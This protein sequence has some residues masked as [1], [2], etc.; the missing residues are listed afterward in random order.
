MSTDY[1]NEFTHNDLESRQK[2][3]IKQELDVNLQQQNIVNQS[4][5]TIKEFFQNIPNTDPDYAI[6]LTQMEMDQI[7]LD[8]LKKREDELV[9][10]IKNSP[11]II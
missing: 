10:F 1:S 4:I 11:P 5:K 8:E 2:L 3:L 9:N 7:H 6:L